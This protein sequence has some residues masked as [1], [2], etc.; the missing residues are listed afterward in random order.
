MT[1]NLSKAP[2]SAT[3]YSVRTD[4]LFTTFWRKEGD[5]F[6]RIWVA[7]AQGFRL[8]E[9]RTPTPYEKDVASVYAK[10]LPSPYQGAVDNTVVASSRETSSPAPQVESGEPRAR[11]KVDYSSLDSYIW[12]Q[13]PCQA[14]FFSLGL[15]GELNCWLRVEEGK[16]VT[17]WT[18]QGTMY[19]YHSSERQPSV[20]GPRFP[21]PQKKEEAS[22]QEW[23]GEGLPPVGCTVQLVDISSPVS[24][25]FDEWLLGDYLEVIAH[26]EVCGTVLPIVWNDRKQTGSS[27]LTRLIS[28]VSQET[29]AAEKE[30]Q[31]GIQEMV[32]L[33][34]SMD[35]ARA[36][37]VLYDAGYRKQ[38]DTE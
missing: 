27:I 34:S 30:R 38:E 10:P 37:E 20:P 23:D 11:G 13:A 35:L 19:N 18:E 33:V 6:T 36:L 26:K 8:P 31:Q 32:S 24:P 2:A 25:P 28:P 22:P 17:V 1:L 9:G 21:R 12:S 29:L 4:S 16:I 5:L 3:H 15:N 14:N 7:D